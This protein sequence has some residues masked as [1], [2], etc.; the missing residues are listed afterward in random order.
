VAA[1]RAPGPPADE[2][3]SLSSRLADVLT[4]DLDVAHET[5]QVLEVA[6]PHRAVRF[7][8]DLER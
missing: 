1:T 3:R 7:G 8:Q 6:V 5:A 2:V 4:R